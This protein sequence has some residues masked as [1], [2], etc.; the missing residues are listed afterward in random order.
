[1][2]ALGKGFGAS[3]NSVGESRAAV[4]VGCDVDEGIEPDERLLAWSRAWEAAPRV[5]IPFGLVIEQRVD[6][7]A[8]P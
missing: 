8:E 6:P 4:A 2:P 7:P 1:M 5:R 3:A